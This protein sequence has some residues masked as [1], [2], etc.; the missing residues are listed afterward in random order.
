MLT[1]YMRPYQDDLHCH[2]QLEQLQ[3]Y[4]CEQY[5]TEEHGS[6]K[7]RIVLEQAIQTLQPEDTLVVSKLFALADSTRHLAELLD[8]I[9]I[10][11]AYLVSIEEKIDTRTVEGKAFYNN[12]HA[13]LH[14]QSDIVSEHTKRGMYEAKE[15][16]IKVGRPR[17]LDDN[18][19]QAIQMYES[20]QYTLAQIREK[21]GISK[22]TL[23][24]YLEN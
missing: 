15:K 8:Q 14:F 13:L 6:A 20:Q 23:Y 18:V 11:Q 4:A 5:V 19:K 7:K 3:Q 10:Q 12:V 24:R 16:G 22:S 9:T 21:T 17:K 1:G 2:H